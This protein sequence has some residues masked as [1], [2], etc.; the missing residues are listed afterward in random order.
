MSEKFSSPSY[1]PEMR[2]CLG[3]KGFDLRKVFALWYERII[4]EELIPEEFRK[5]VM[6]PG[7]RKQIIDKRVPGWTYHPDK[8]EGGAMVVCPEVWADEDDP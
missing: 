1:P 4:P 6:L 5:E 8:G 2:V 3:K 7:G